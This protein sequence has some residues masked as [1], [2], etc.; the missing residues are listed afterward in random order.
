MNLAG[1]CNA[2]GTKKQFEEVTLSS[3][4]SKFNENG[5]YC[6]AN[7]LKRNKIN[8]TGATVK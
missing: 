6:C 7:L 5:R 3:G 8:E 1:F 2:G 4:K